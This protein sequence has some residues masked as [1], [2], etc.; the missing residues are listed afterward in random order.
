[1][2]CSLLYRCC[3]FSLDLLLRYA[4]VD[5]VFNSLPSCVWFVRKNAIEFGVLT[6]IQK[7]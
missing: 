1:M 4:I 2:L 5:A 6:G 3:T 7:S